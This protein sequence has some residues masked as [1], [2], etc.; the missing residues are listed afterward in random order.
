MSELVGDAARRVIGN[1]LASACKRHLEEA[2][3]ALAEFDR[4]RDLQCF[5]RLEK[6]AEA[7]QRLAGQAYHL[8]EA[9]RDD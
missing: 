9:R 2:Q 7:A 6:H 5:V 3:A 1:S 8:D 4:T